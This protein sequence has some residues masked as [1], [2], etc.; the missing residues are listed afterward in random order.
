MQIQDLKRTN[1]HFET[2]KKPQESFEQFVDQFET[3]QKLVVNLDQFTTFT[4]L[5]RDPSIHNH[6]ILINLVVGHIKKSQDA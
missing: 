5:L 4:S 1:S 2:I 6:P 3:T